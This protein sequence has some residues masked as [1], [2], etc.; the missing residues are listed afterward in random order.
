MGAVAPSWLI[1]RP[2]AMSSRHDT[3]QRLFQQIHQLCLFGDALQVSP[4]CFEPGLTQH[5][6]Q[7]PSHK[8]YH[9][10]GH[11]SAAPGYRSSLELLDWQLPQVRVMS[12]IPILPATTAQKERTRTKKKHAEGLHVGSCSQG[13][14]RLSI[15]VRKSQSPAATC[16]FFF[17]G[18]KGQTHHPPCKRSI[19]CPCKARRQAWPLG[20]PPF[21]VKTPARAGQPPTPSEDPLP[22]YQRPS[23]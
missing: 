2:Q 21:L 14:Q 5:K 15:I 10:A 12:M 3:A 22:E 11:S 4:Q 16:Q 7:K 9:M 6:V 20:S 13:I 23:W 18:G 19:A 17:L 8:S 1:F